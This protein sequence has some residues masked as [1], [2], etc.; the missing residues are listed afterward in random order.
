[1]IKRFL[2]E[3]IYSS[4]TKK[5]SSISLNL[6]HPTTISFHS[7]QEFVLFDSKDILLDGCSIFYRNWFEKG[8]YLIQDLLDVNGNTMS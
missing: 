8:V 2:Q 7:R 3:P 4:S 6:R 5:S 1:M